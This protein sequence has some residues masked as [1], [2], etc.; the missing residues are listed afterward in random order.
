[1][2]N[3]PLYSHCFE[4]NGYFSSSCFSSLLH[5]GC[6]QQEQGECRRMVVVVVVGGGGGGGEVSHELA[7]LP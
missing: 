2:A 6:K 1:M 5:R 3:I 7:P 4:P